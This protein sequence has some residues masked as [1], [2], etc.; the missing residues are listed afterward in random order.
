MRSWP[1]K[2]KA[3][4]VG[5]HPEGL[6]TAN[7]GPPE[8]AGIQ[9]PLV[10]AGLL[11]WWGVDDFP[12]WLGVVDFLPWPEVDGCP[13]WFE[14]DPCQLPSGVGRVLSCCFPEAPVAGVSVQ[15]GH[16]E[17]VYVMCDKDGLL[18]L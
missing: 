2:M 14:V 11:L 15:A 5:P 6:R 18:S 1:E 7:E 17:Y 12:P 8:A 13:P 9:P 3:P 16:R 10:E 4:E